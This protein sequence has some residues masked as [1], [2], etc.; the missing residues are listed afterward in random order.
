MKNLFKSKGLV[1]ERIVYLVRHG[2]TE[3]NKKRFYMGW[4]EEELSEEGIKQAEVLGLKLKEKEISK[5]YTSP[6]RRAVQTAEILNKYLS[7]EITMEKD[8]GEM[9]LGEWEGM[10]EEKVKIKYPREWAMWNK[11]PKEL[12]LPGRETLDSVQQ[13]S[14]RAIKKILNMSQSRNVVAV[15]HVAIIR[16]LM[17]FFNNLDLNLYKRI[18][19]PNA[20]ASELKLLEKNRIFLG[21]CSEKIRKACISSG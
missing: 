18:A 2:V 5:I 8:L 16:C 4:S 1:E 10:S 12:K 6:V 20:S 13:R 15:S 21:M 11:C 17:L 14:L 9:K 19:V 7:T 3:S